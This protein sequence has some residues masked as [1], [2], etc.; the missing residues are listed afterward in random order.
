LIIGSN[1]G[2]EYIALDARESGALPVVALDM[3]N[4]DLK[5]T[6]LPIAENFDAFV[7]LIGIAA[8]A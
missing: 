6:V 2:G 3:T 5:D 4:A 1:G 8:T 7:E